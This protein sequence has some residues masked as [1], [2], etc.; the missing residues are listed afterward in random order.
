MEEMRG[1]SGDFSSRG[2]SSTFK[3]PR[4][5]SYCFSL[6]LTVPWPVPPPLTPPLLCPFRSK[7]SLF[8]EVVSVTSAAPL[9]LSSP[10]GAWQAKRFLAAELWVGIHGGSRRRKITMPSLQ[11]AD[12][13]GGPFSPDEREN[14]RVASLPWWRAPVPNLGG[15]S[16]N[17]FPGFPECLFGSCVSYCTRHWGCSVKKENH[18]PRLQPV[19]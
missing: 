9:G 12:D 15:C 13:S 7:E 6:L 3:T 17:A 2:S 11:Y 14:L 1:Q 18:T 16:K 19:F 5:V 10:G 4:S 8:P